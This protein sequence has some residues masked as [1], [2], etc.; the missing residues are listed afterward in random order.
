MDEPCYTIVR[1]PKGFEM[2][3]E[4]ALK[5]AIEGNDPIDVRQAIEALLQSRLDG[6]K[7]PPSLLMPIINRYQ[8][9]CLGTAPGADKKLKKLLYLLW[10]CLPKR[11]PDNKFL[12]NLVMVCGA[13]DRDLKHPNQY[14]CGNVLRL[15]SKTREPEVIRELVNSIEKCLDL[16]H[17]YQRKNSVLSMAKI[18]EN[19]PEV[20][21]NA[22]G[23][24]SDYLA[25]ETDDECKR[26]A[27]QALLRIAPNEAKEY[28]HSLR[29]KH[30]IQ[31][32]SIQLSIVESIQ[33]SY[34]KS[35]DDT[36]MNVEI[37]KNLIKMSSSPSVRYQA[38]TT[39]MKI[40][41]DSISI[42]TV[43]SCFVDICS[44][45]S[46]NNVKLIALDSL[47]NLKKTT[48]GAD[49]ILRGL[50]M[51]IL[52]ILQSASDLELRQKILQLSLD[53][54]SSAT[55][56]E[57]VSKLS[58]ETRD[59]FGTNIQGT[60]E[61]ALKYR[62]LLIETI[63]KVSDRYPK[64]MVEGDM[65][66]TLFNLLTCATIGE[67]TSTRLIL[68][69][70][71]FMCKN[72]NYR[73]LV[74]KQIQDSFNIAKNNL[75]THKGLLW[76]LGDFSEGKSQ[77]ERSLQVISNSIGTLPITDSRRKRTRNES[78]VDSKD[79]SKDLDS[80]EVAK[81]TKGVKSLVTADGTY[82]TQSAIAYQGNSTKSDIELPPLRSY[83]LKGKFD[84]ASILGHAFVKMSC[85]YLEDKSTSVAE[86][87]K[88]V[89]SCMLTLA[90]ILNMGHSNFL[91][92]EGNLIE[93]DQD[94]EEQIMLCLSILRLIMEE[95]HE[96][97]YKKIKNIFTTEMKF[98]LQ[99]MIKNLEKENADVEKSKKSSKQKTFDDSIKL[100]ML[101]SK[102]DFLPELEN[103]DDFNA[104]IESRIFS[105]DLFNQIPLTGTNDPIYASCEF[106]VNQ[107]NIGM[108]IFIENRAK[109]SSD[110]FGSDK[111][112]ENVALELSTRGDTTS[113]LIDKP[114]PFVL[115]PRGSRYINTSVRVTSTENR[116][117][118]GT[119]S[120]D[121]VESSHEHE[122]KEQII[123]LNDIS[124][125]VTDYI[126]PAACSY[127][128][129]RDLWRDCEWENKV[130]VKTKVTDLKEFLD[131][132]I[133]AT[134]MKCITP[135]RALSGECSFLC[136]NLYA[137]TLFGEDALVNVSLEKP[138]DVVTGHVK[139][140]SRSQK[141]ALS[142]GEKITAVQV[143]SELH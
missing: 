12:S 34:H 67:R 24:I 36:K 101:L 5:K 17:P 15:L 107:Y 56:G 121:D 112:L 99:L 48:E 104:D 97:V 114:E 86:T 131:L 18:Y 2:A 118:F 13:F 19:F 133:K 79:D 98:S 11:T 81:I 91:D 116:K 30:Y 85:K 39:L 123:T 4:M 62:R 115:A 44:K 103:V 63:H 95:N 72:L 111:I 3:N 21:P 89:G 54:V 88:F 70:K 140:R 110:R 96:E 130:S 57:L 120:Y 119:I 37:L 77:I 31:P 80:E 8:M 22:I 75:S 132:L 29:E 49:K 42:K 139:I 66:E 65:L 84:F 25:K 105:N 125:N 45:E 27:L 53:L 134:N 113:S 90:S 128:D 143:A 117:L 78:S 135:E 129:F 59:I 43:A 20:I 32:T 55:I 69:F 127:D 142:L 40:S 68:L 106:D 41:R 76:I 61:E 124:I 83:L 1:K 136:S 9:N 137:K 23:R 93:I 73:D 100:P 92:N 6:E 33:R 82:A 126:K 94:Q 102:E 58:Q 51:N 38:A 109:T 28:L 47:I 74:I 64:A 138:N 141:L 71:V 60:Q 46:D 87:N 7:F 50:L 14:V 10:E 26:A 122:K 52:I 35:A 108:K 16:S